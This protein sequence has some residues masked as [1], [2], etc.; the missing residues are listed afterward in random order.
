MENKEKE[1]KEHKVKRIAALVC[2]ILIVLLYLVTFV[3]SFFANKGMA[4]AF[5][6][7]AVLTVALPL[8]TWGFIWM[9]GK[10]TNKKT[11]ASL[12][13]DDPLDDSNEEPADDK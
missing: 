11:I 2:I 1:T 7:C 9:Y 3:I 13:P 10:L 5:R 6:I 12:F 8:F 4:S